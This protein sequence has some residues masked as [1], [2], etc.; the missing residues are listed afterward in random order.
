MN[1]TR[2]IISARGARSAK[3]ITERSLIGERGVALLRKRVLDM[4]YVWHDRRVDAGIDG[5]IELRDPATEVALNRLILVQSKA[6]EQPLTR[7]TAASFE[8]LCSPADLAYWLDGNAPV[9][10]VCSHPSTDEAWWVSIKDYFADP[11]RRASRRVHFDKRTMR[12]DASAATALF[13]LAMPA[14][15]G[16]YLPPPPRREQLT[17]NLLAVISVPPRIRSAPT[18]ATDGAD[19]VARL[20]EVGAR[21]SDFLLRAGQV[22]SFRALTEAPLSTLVAGDPLVV[23]TLVPT[24]TWADS[25]DVNLLR[26]YVELLTRTLRDMLHAELAWCAPGRYLYFKATSSLNP[27]RIR[28]SSGRRRTVFTP[29]YRNPDDPTNLSYCRHDA[30]LPR[31]ARVD[32]RWYLQVSPTYHYTRDGHQPSLFADELLSGLKRRERHRAVFLQ[33]K[34]WANY[35]QDDLRLREREPPL[36]FGRLATVDVDRGIDEARWKLERIDGTADEDDLLSSNDPVDM[37]LPDTRAASE[38][39]SNAT[40]PTLFDDEDLL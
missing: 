25:D 2:V 24:S 26:W 10:L 7:E 8:Y 34:M 31:F 33:V 14:E 9:L 30:F 6:S 11:V 35:L 38:D 37:D 18:C 19:A 16:L 32:G 12:F 22:H 21:D 40:E 1:Y 28:S 5:E 27:R 29:Y 4:G 17:S 20:A 23:S 13:D 15:S 36:R 39:D 3:K